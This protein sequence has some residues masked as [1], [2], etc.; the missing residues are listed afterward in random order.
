MPRKIIVILFDLQPTYSI[1][2]AM[3]N[4][5]IFSSLV[6]TSLKANSLFQTP[7]GHNKMFFLF[8]ML[9]PPSG[10]FERKKFQIFPDTGKA[11][12]RPRTPHICMRKGQLM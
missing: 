1:S 3:L 2:R 9:I 12:V 7:F 4:T 11:Q 5:A 10:F 6:F 8:T